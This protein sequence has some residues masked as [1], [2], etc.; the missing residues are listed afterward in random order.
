MKLTSA[1]APSI[2]NG[3]IFLYYSSKK[4]KVVNC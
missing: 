4:L 2:T 3:R 1:Q